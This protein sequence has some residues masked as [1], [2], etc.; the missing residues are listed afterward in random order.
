MNDNVCELV[1]FSKI[2]DIVIKFLEMV[3]FTRAKFYLY[4]TTSIFLTLITAG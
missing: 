4:K 3:T 2:H 1:G